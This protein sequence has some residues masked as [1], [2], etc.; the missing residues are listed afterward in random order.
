MG[1]HVC[2]CVGGGGEEGRRGGDERY[3][4]EPVNWHMFFHVK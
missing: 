3:L 4:D 1:V 2:V